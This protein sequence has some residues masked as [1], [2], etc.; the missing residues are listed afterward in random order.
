MDILRFVRISSSLRFSCNDSYLFSFAEASLS[1]FPR[2][3]A[4]AVPFGGLGSLRDSQGGPPNPLSYPGLVSSAASDFF[5]LPRPPSFPSLYTSAAPPTTMA[6]PGSM[7]W[8]LTSSDHK[9]IKP[10]SQTPPT[11]KDRA[12]RPK[13][14]PSPRNN[15]V[16]RSNGGVE[17]S[18]SPSSMMRPPSTSSSPS[19]VRSEQL[20]S[21]SSLDLSFKKEEEVSIVGEKVNHV[22]NGR[23]SVDNRP[24]SRHSSNKVRENK[25]LAASLARPPLSSP[26]LG[27]PSAA[28][29]ANP[30]GLPGLYPHLGH[31]GLQHHLFGLDPYR[32]AAAA[33]LN[34][35][36]QSRESLLRFNQLMMTE[37]ERIRMGLNY[38]TAPPTPG[39]FPPPGASGATPGSLMAKPPAPPSLG[40]PPGFPPGYG[41][42]AAAAAAAS[43][44][45][46]HLPPGAGLNG[47]A[48]NVSNA[49]STYHASEHHHHP[50][51]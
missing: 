42:S 1:A 38:P 26:A 7:G 21:T 34:P 25:T 44:G 11:P 28:S 43:L 22:P 50:L 15:G 32:A 33:S 13:E 51:R 17:A 46:G 35:Y 41:A 4:S 31:P 8:P 47:H 30:F 5:G 48:P 10:P 49:G 45:L 6:S 3:G 18:R 14:S 20:P 2:F 39:L 40:Y 24:P 36:L 37:Q 29:A 27:P 16:V 12:S 9:K 23:T 19:I